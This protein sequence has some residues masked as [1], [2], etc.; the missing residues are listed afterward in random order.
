MHLVMA[1]VTAPSHVYPGLPVIAELVARGHRLTYVVGERLRDLVAATGAEV[2]GLDSI[3]PDA[4][5]HWPEDT[6]AAMQ[7]FLDDAVAALE[8]MLKR[9][10]RPDAVLY[11]I[12]GPAGRVAAPH[13]GVPAVQPSTAS[14]ALA[15]L[16]GATAAH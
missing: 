5:E 6:G 16:E 2:L 3:M 12:G 1:G 9:I 4:D 7:V 13:P 10:D 8:P 11:D 15:A 14:A